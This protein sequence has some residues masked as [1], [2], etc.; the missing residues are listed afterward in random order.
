MGTAS[1]CTSVGWYLRQTPS[2]G[3]AEVASAYGTPDYEPVTGDWNGDGVDGIG[4]YVQ[5]D[6]YL[7]AVASPGAPQAAFGYGIRSYW[8]VVGD[9]D[10]DGRDGSGVVAP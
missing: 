10:G 3:F 7:R 9:F 8:P 1:G 2:P 5:G 6:W 4:V